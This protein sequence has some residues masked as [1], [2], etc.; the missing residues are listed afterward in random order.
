MK[1]QTIAKNPVLF[2]RFTGLTIQEFSTLSR[3]LKPLWDKAERERLSRNDRKRNIGGGRKYKLQQF[4]DKLLVILMFYKL[5]FTFEVLGFLFFDLDKSCISRLIYRLEPILSKRLKLPEIK[6]D[7]DKPV[8]SVEEMLTIYPEMREFIGDATE[9]E[10]PRPKDRRN[11]KKY[12]SGKKKRHTVKTELALEK[13]H[14]L[15]YEV[16]PPVPGSVHD[17]TLLK[18]TNLPY[19]LPDHSKL[20]LDK[21]YDGAKKDF[22][23]YAVTII[24]PKKANRW[25]KLSKRDRFENRKIGKNRIPIEHGI[26]KCKRFN[27]LRQIYR[28]SLKNYGLRFKNI[29]GL[30]NFK[31]QNSI[32]QLEQRTQ[33]GTLAAVT[34]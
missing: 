15:L 6:R 22:S 10:I 3:E 11:R 31:V 14:G 7:R 21:G 16:S 23:N 13:K 4:N 25:H 5:Y 18:K 29:A 2:S 34:V 32:K 26:L 19:H 24:I 1:Y 8:S 12:Y 17:Y 9:Q 33:V 27:L 28:H 20:Y 30:V